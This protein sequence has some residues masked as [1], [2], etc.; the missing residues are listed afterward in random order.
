MGVRKVT[1]VEFIQ[2][3]YQEAVFTQLGSHDYHLHKEG[4]PFN[5]EEFYT[6]PEHYDGN[7]L[8]YAR[9]A[10]VLI[11]GAF[12]DPKAP[13][14]FTRQE[15]LA[16]DFKIKVIA[17]IT[18]D[19]E[20]S[21]PSTLQAST[22]ADPIYDYN[23]STGKMETALR[24]EDNIT[25]MAVDNLPCELPRNASDD[26]GRDLLANVVPSLLGDDSDGIIARATICENG[27]LTERFSYLKDY[28]EGR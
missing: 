11:A 26:F 2:K 5:R 21:I 10:D 13:M 1:P 7:F 28:L 27:V 14:L 24:D 20:G 3:D 19:I 23:P 4:K 8:P 16:P 17:D 9:V 22:I 18:C 15:A 12:W 6:H 25:V